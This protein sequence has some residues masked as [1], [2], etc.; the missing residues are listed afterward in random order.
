MSNKLSNLIAVLLL[1]IMAV[2]A[3]TSMRGASATFDELAHIPAGYS[4]LS[5][6]D[7]RV[8]PEHPPLVKD[9]AAFP[10]TFINPNF[11]DEKSVWKNADPSVWWTQFDLGT[12]FLYRSG[13]N[14]EKLVTWSR[15]PMI[16]ILIL[17]A[18][19]LYYW[20]KKLRDKKV[21]LLVLT[22]FTFSPT[23][24]AHGRFVTND[25]AAALGFVLG[26]MFWLK[27]LKKPN[28]KNVILAGLA[29]GVALLIKFSLALLIPLVVL[30]T[31]IYAWLYQKSFVRYLALGLAAGLIGLALIWIVYQFHVINYPIEKQLAHTKSALATNDN[32]LTPLTIW[33]ANKPGFRAIGHY[34][35]GLLMA[36]QRTA[37]GNS[38]Y[39]MGMI[40]GTGW[41][42]YFPLVYFLK[43][44][45]AFHG[46]TLLTILGAT[47]YSGKAFWKNSWS[48]LKHCIKSNFGLFTSFLFLLIYWYA[49]IKGSLNI[50]VRHILPTLPFI[51]LLIAS[52]VKFIFRK[53]KKSSVRIGAALGLVTLLVWYITVSAMAWPHYLTFFNAVGGG[54]DQGYKY[55]VDSNYDW[56][57]DMRRLKTWVDKHNVEEIYLDYFGGADPAYYLGDKYKKWKAEASPS[58]L[59]PN[60][61]FAISI[62]QLQ[63]GRAYPVKNYGGPVGHYRWLNDE[64][65][66][67]RAGKTIFIYRVD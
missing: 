18:A 16:G 29:V 1:I 65:L 43:L 6:Q 17:L 42:F 4:Y 61:Y 27:W 10:L 8:N 2:C 32:P 56:G 40:S 34:L 38:V 36:T 52:G 50:G 44:P 48:R 51:Y 64:E 24:L 47:Y 31:L 19:L 25:V 53:I 46:L 30:T 20:I 49:S 58:E 14:A 13:N 66:I 45:L 5:Q 67:D 57:Q 55:V 23:F 9:A 54:Q 35:M 39:L 28:W 37:Q 62:N 63:G 12:E 15:I 11:P 60:S 7:Y 3:Y 21:A 22:L 33:M 41:W 26:I 59:P